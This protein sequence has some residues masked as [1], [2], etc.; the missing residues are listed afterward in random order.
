MASWI[1]WKREWNWT[2]TTDVRLQSQRTVG[3][4]TPTSSPPRLKTL[5]DK[6]WSSSIRLGAASDTIRQSKL[7]GDSTSVRCGLLLSFLGVTVLL[8]GCSSE[9]E[10]DLIRCKASAVETNREQMS[11]EKLAAY[12][13][14]CMRDKSRLLKRVEAASAG[15]SFG[16][17]ASQSGV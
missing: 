8:T 7:A 10:K 1:E 3:P 14:E 6:V 12:L 9:V 11:G 16:N 15:F 5:E 17:T 2:K 13:R 4:Q